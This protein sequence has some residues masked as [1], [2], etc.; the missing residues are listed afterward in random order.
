MLAGYLPFDDDPANPEG[1]NINLLYKYIVSTP[2]TFPEYVTP[3]ARDLLRRILVPDPRRRAD[4]FEVAR[5]SWL[6]EY[7][8]VVGFIGSNNKD[9]QDIASSAVPQDME[10]TLGRSAS[11]REPQSRTASASAAISKPTPMDTVEER[12]GQRDAKRRTVQV[13][14][15]APNA[16]HP[17]GETSPITPQQATMP[18][19]GTGRTRARPEAQGP[20]EVVPNA[21]RL[22][23]VPRKEVGSQAMPPPSRSGRDQ[24]RSSDGNAFAPQSASGRPTTRGTLASRG[25][26]YS[27]PAVATSTAETAQGSFS[28]PKSGSGYIISGSM[29][30]PS[31]AGQTPAADSVNGSEQSVSQMQPAQ[32]LPQS[33]QRGH[34]RSSTLGS[35]TDRMLGRSGS[36]R[37][38]Q[39]AQESSTP[40]EKRDRRHPPVSMANKMGNNHDDSGRRPST[41]S[42]R[43]SFQFLRK[44]AEQ[45]PNESRR[46]SRRFSF[47]PNN[48]SM[49]SFSG[50][51]REDSAA[52]NS[53]R[54]ESRTDRPTSKGMAFGR[55][56]S[57]SPTRSTAS[58][59]VPHYYDAE[60][61]KAINRRSGVPQDKALP[62]V[63]QQS[64]RTPP[65]PA[66]RTQYRDDGY[67][68]ALQQE[69]V[70]RYYTPNQDLGPPS[71]ASDVQPH[72]P[73]VSRS[74]YPTSSHQSQQ[75]Q[76]SQQS[77]RP[78][79]RKFDDAYEKGHDG[80]SSGARRVMDFFRRRGRERGGE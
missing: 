9:E 40:G 69:P 31:A 32:Q 42:R 4:L 41:D 36:R 21:Q 60:A 13:E 12:K 79:Q 24:N 27:Q 61:Q 30:P 6:S 33:N 35:I 47:L 49:N 75:Q 8:H 58:S 56:A 62:F 34:K 39:Q 48:F 53:G 63:P 54:R 67:N 1:D 37:Q 76:N 15:V 3:H 72:F 78:N 43:S 5:H 26:S 18:I 73:P 46:N 57:R 38:S 77:M 50:A 20:V 64:Q 7:S 25:N 80:S 68:G 45:Q 22:P 65:P 66:S 71:A 17:R 59:S 51:K 44:N 14:Y 52:E 11:V 2:L 23:Q 28:R 29:P 16:A 70:E 19:A 74:P 55:G 10:P